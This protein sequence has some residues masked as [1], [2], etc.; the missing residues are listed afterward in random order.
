M[1]ILIITHSYH[2]VTDSRAFRWS[3][4]CEQ[5]AGMGIIV[6]VICPHR[7]T[8]SSTKLEN[9]NGVNVYRVSD[10]SQRFR[11]LEFVK[12]YADGTRES[13][14]RTRMKKI[15]HAVMK[16][17]T[18]LL[19]W[20]DFAWL[21]IPRVYL[22]GTRLLKTHQYEGIISVAHPFSSHLAVMLLRQR[23]KDIPW[24]CDYGDPFSF[25]TE[26]FINNA[27]LYQGLNNYIERKIMQTSKNIAVTTAETAKQYIAHLGVPQSWFHVIPPLV[28][29]NYTAID[30]EKVNISGDN[31]VIRLLFAG[32]LY[33]KIRNPSFCLALLAEARTR[34]SSHRLEVHFYGPMNDCEPMFTEYKD[35]INQW[36]FV[37]GW[38]D[39]TEL[40]SIYNSV[41]ILVNIGN[42]TTYQA[43]S[44]VI[45]YIATGLPILNITSLIDDSSLPLLQDYPVALSLFQGNGITANII[46]EL[47][48]FLIH[49]QRA[50]VDVVNAI[51]T[52]Y[53]LAAVANSYLKLFETA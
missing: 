22:L 35:A 42:A 36:L 21:W 27:R 13:S 48:T 34:L 12:V 25:L 7:D 51:L 29:S 38:I 11:T 28:T 19:R 44:K 32:T 20:P 47:C 8:S 37:H 33:A 40:M 43:P 3:A 5:W 45:E 18:L 14:W 1:R 4:I 26:A 49:G 46:D 30:E 53:Q 6:D 15:T 41:D 17:I 50:S 24:V 39:K 10:P 52:E 2:P 16:K 31:K 9:I 23:R